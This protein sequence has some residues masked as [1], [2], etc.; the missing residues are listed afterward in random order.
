MI[1]LG[2]GRVVEAGNSR[3]GVAVRPASFHGDNIG[4]AALV[5][6]LKY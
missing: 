6:G 4:Y 2:D 5:P 3:V 1:S